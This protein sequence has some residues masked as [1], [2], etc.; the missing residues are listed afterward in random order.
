MAV[1]PAAKTAPRMAN[2]QDSFEYPPIPPGHIRM[3]CLEWKIGEKSPHGRLSVWPVESPSPYDALSYVWGKPEP[4]FPFYCN[5][6]VFRISSN[7]NLA[8][9]HLAEPGQSRYLW[10]DQICIN[11]KDGSEKETQIR[12]MDQI[13]GSANKVAIWLGEAPAE[14]D[15]VLHSMHSIVKALEDF[16]GT[17][18]VRKEN[19]EFLGLPA[20]SSAVWGALRVIFSSSWFERLWTLQEAVLART[21][22]I[23]IGSHIID[24]N[25]LSSLSLA[26]SKANLV[27]FCRNDTS[28]LK[29]RVDGHGSITQ[30]HFLRQCRALLGHVVL[31][32]V[33]EATRTRLCTVEVDRFYAI[34]GLVHKEVRG[35]MLIDYN[36]SIQATFINFFKLVIELDATLCLLHTPCTRNDT[37][38]LPSWCPNIC[39]PSAASALGVF[40]LGAGYR[41]GCR[42]FPK[43][44]SGFKVLS[45]SNNVQVPGLNIDRVTTV[46]PMEFQFPGTDEPD[47]ARQALEWEASCLK[48]AQEIYEMSGGVPEQH[49][50]TLIANKLHTGQPCATNLIEAYHNMKK[51]LQYRTTSVDRMPGTDDEIVRSME[52]VT[53]VVAAC[54]GRRYFA[55]ENGRVGL[56]PEDIMPGDLVCIFFSGPVPYIL[57]P[58]QHTSNCMFLGESYVH[59]LMNSEALDML[60]QGDIQTTTFELE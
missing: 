39:Q 60:D 3:L 14:M 46:V 5:G 16:N 43:K 57:R 2:S 53:A 36:S 37:L 12:L 30:I 58:S 9:H 41:A 25:A 31:P 59:G 49:W 52:F 27:S 38:H 45:E 21:L 13:Y 26:I 4:T 33:I 55:T 1:L 44:T 24:W 7:L 51:Y 48:I 29:D 23:H 20:M 17:V 18:L 54:Y 8:L 10:I 42:Q 56:G 15:L 19:F 47:I 40:S 50:R 28:R 35:R 11:Q 32:L 6:T 22:E 34:T